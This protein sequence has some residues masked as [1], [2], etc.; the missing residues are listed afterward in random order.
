[1]RT[2]LREFRVSKSPPRSRIVGA[3][4]EAPRIALSAA[5]FLA[6]A[7]CAALARS[8]TLTWDASGTATSTATAT[9]GSGNWNAGTPRWNNG[10]TDQGWTSAADTAVI[11]GGNGPAGTLTLTAPLTVAGLV[12]NAAGSGNYL[13]TGSTLTLGGTRTITANADATIGSA[14]T[15]AGGSFTKAG[16]GRL[17]LLRTA[18]GNVTI[19]FPLIISGGTL[20]FAVNNPTGLVQIL[21]AVTGA[22]GTTIRVSGVGY[23]RNDSLTANWSANRASLDVGAGAAFDLRGQGITVDALTGGGTV[24]DSYQ[25]GPNTLTVGINNGSGAFSGTIQQ[26][27]FNVGTTGTPVVALS[28]VGNGT[29]TLYGVNTYSGGTSVTGGTLQ[30]SADNNLGAASGGLTLNAGA[31]RSTASFASARTVTLGVGSGTFNTNAN[32]ILQLNGVIG[33]IGSLVKAGTGQLTL[34]GANTYGVGTSITGGVLQV[35]A[36]NNLGVATGSIVFSNNSTLR[37]GAG[38]ASA[39]SLTLNGVGGTL[40][41]NGNAAQLSGVIGG[42]GALTK[43]A[44]GVLTLTG[45]NTYAGGTVIN[46]GALQVSANNNLGATTGGLALSGGTLQYATGFSSART[47][48]LGA[49]GGTFDTH[50]NDATLTGVV[51]GAGALAKTGAGSMTLTGASAYS[52]GTA[53]LEG[54]IDIGDGGALGTGS[55][56]MSEGTTLGFTVNG[57]TLAN[58]VLLTGTTDPI[59]DTGSF[60]E[61]LTGVISGPGTLTKSGIGTLVVSAANTYTG[62]TNVAQGT[63]RA[64]APNTFSAASAHVVAAGAT[65]D[66]AGFNQRVAS[67]SN[68]GTVSLVGG[69][70]GTTLSVNGA[71]VGNAGLLKVATALTAGGPVSNRLVLD[72][73]AATA[74]GNT[75]IQ[76]TN[77]S[78]LGTPTTG[79]GIN[80]ITALNG[81]A[82]T[83]QTSKTAF[84]LAGG[85]VDAGAFEYRLYAADAAGAGNGWFLRTDAPVNPVTSATFVTI[86]GDP[87][88]PTTP[89]VSATSAAAISRPT[90]RADVPLYAALP[91]VLRQSDLAMLSNL[92][93]RVGDE[94]ASIDGS[95]PSSANRR[96]WG[97]VLG[98]TTTV[99]QTGATAPNSRIDMEGI[100]AGVDFFA[101]GSWNAGV[102]AGTLRSDARVD[103]LY[104]LNSTPAY[105]GKLRADTVSLGGYATYAN[106]RGQYADFV[107]QYGR[108]ELTIDSSNGTHTSGDARSV[109]ASAEVGQR[110]PMGSDWGIEPQV[111]LIYNRQDVDSALISGATIAQDSANAVIGRLGVRMT[112][113]FTTGAGR[114]RPYARLNLWHGFRGTD[115]T[116]FIGPA[117][118]TSIANG[119][120]YTSTEVAAGFTQAL[121]QTASLYGEIGKLFHAGGGQAQ[122]KSSV[123]ASLGIQLRF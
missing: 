37:Y 77:L 41:T 57:L 99:A 29:Q 54:R 90:Y 32:T 16:A 55:L 73:A 34:T 53:L 82:T 11:G 17:T 79:N 75:T 72:G 35:S 46:G 105:A 61:T 63:V 104:G 64:G 93:R 66:T 95:A 62:T 68:S 69:A 84:A 80:I 44:A 103:G 119:I 39:R 115:S 114:L 107:L 98:G 20:E 111:Q 100:Q 106:R 18:A 94:S 48:T 36:N 122:V 25:N 85:H 15:V 26:V 117:G 4:S 22:A 24:A 108:H 14:F 112:G 47:V 109:V 91:D 59:M 74:S 2:R 30:V 7:L 33:G 83:A 89:A 43:T 116:S 81:A 50:G 5:A 9:D 102:Y 67:L 58:A 87:T 21:S 96:A 23:V 71:Y 120:G 113:D 76:I 31:L 60:T 51:G 19:G 70:P 40:D 3:R 13:V 110:L 8:A 65:L 1:V 86:P 92:H 78:G 38:F 10:V 27:G 97:R 12:F 52:G 42:A 45:A 6:T 101:D 56:A 88:V 49:G 121:T 123:Q 118:G 28:K